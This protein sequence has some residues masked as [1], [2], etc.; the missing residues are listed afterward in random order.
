MGAEIRRNI[1]Q[2]ITGSSLSRLTSFQLGIILLLTCS[3]LLHAHDVNDRLSI[4]FLTAVATQCQDIGNGGP[5]ECEQGYVFQP[6]ISFNDAGVNS[7]F[8]KLGFGRRNALNPVSH[9]SV[10]PWAADLEDD[11]E[12]INGR[13]RDNILTAWYRRRF[14]LTG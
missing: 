3:T 11:V 6:E 7:V 12:N 1:R 5:D 14:H 9:F 4:G 10:A 2:S 13:R 8:V